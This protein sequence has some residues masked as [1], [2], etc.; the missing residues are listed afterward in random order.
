MENK[1]G[2]I[3]RRNN[4]TSASTLPEVGKIKIG[5]KHPEKGYPMSLDYFKA[6]GSYA[7][8]FYRIYGDKPTKLTVAF[9]SN[10]LSEVCNERYECWDKGKRWGWGDGETFEVWDGSRYVQVDKTSE[11]LKGKKWDLMLT[12]RFVLLEM[13]GVMGYWTFTT[14]GKETTIPSI[15]KSFDFVRERA[16][17]I[18][19]FPFDLIVEKKK[20]YN[21]GEA[22]NYP[23]VQLVPNFSEAT[24]EKV[25][26]YI[27]QGGNMNKV[28]TSFIQQV[29][30]QKMIGGA[31]D[32]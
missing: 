13:R 10:E 8:E 9:I 21:P 16:N 12:L 30:Q 17:T 20:G 4:Q 31:K 19:G 14:K 7:N 2:R 11:L 24:M 28:T 3:A 26:A 25:A 23:T 29:E 32:E 1:T 6:T 5:E 22:R 15:V 18:V 27:E